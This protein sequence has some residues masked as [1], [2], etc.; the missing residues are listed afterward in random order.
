MKIKI[1]KDTRPIATMAR[2]YRKLADEIL[3]LKREHD[4]VFKLLETLQT[5]QEALL[6][7]IKDQ[8]RA[9]AEEG[10]TRRLVDTEKVSVEVAG[11]VAKPVYDYR[12]ALKKWSLDALRQASVVD[13]KAVQTLLE[14]GVLTE[15]EVEAVQV[16]GASLTP[17]VTVKVL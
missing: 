12:L 10:E 13:P 8:A 11:P 4:G 6:I 5:A 1:K 15:D 17:R 14:D 7:R 2:E 3:E 9:M 16:P